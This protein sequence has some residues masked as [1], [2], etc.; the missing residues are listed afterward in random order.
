M[1]KEHLA[2]TELFSHVEDATSFHVPRVFVPKSWHGHIEI[3]QP[4]E[5]NT[6]LIAV[7]T[8]NPLIDNNISPLDFRI[9]KFM[10]LELVAAVIIAVFFIA[11]ARH[12]RGGKH[13]RGRLWNALEVMLL[14]FRDQVARPCIGK[15]DA[16]RFVPFLWTMFFFVLGCNLFGMIPWMGSPTGALA[17]TGMLALITFGV[18]VVGGMTK[19]GVVGFW[20]AQVPS[21]DLPLLIAIPLVPLIFVIEIAGLLIKH[22]VLAVRLLANMMAG[23]V[24][25]AVL[26]GFIGATYGLAAWWGVM[27]LSV[28]GAT[29]LSLLE[30]FVAFLQAYIFT[31]L[32]ALFIGMAVHP[33]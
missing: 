30:L 2:P 1:A 13:P 20:K 21:M 3:P 26:V 5:L 25:L 7:D 17:T 14:F 10:I 12:L 4:F 29:A 33:H 31:F 6:P 16:D 19:L 18:V 27:P 28:I 24:V 9:T 8:G 23:H 11:L 32:S 15:H 22:A